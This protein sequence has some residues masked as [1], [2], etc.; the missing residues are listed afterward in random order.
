[1]IRDFLPYLPFLLKGK[2]DVE[3]GIEL[4]KEDLAV[5]VN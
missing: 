4:A 3:E 1:V 5:L 2:K